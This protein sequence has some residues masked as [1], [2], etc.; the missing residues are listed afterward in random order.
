M[1]NYSYVAIDPRGLETRGRLDVSDQS[2][3]LRRIREM[4]LFPTKVLEANE[5]RGPA[6]ARPPRPGLAKWNLT[7]TIPGF[8]GRV[9]TTSLT[10]F[11]RQLS[12]LV[13]AGL[14]LLR[15]LRLLEEQ[16]SNPTL[17]QI[18]GDLSF[19]IEGGSSLGDAVAAHPRVF[20]R[21]YVN[22]VKAGEISGALEITLRRLAE[23]MEKTQRIK[24][25]IKAA[26][27]YPCAVLSV[28]GAILM[29]LLAYVVPKFKLVFADMLGN[30]RLPVFTRFILAISDTVKAHVFV[31]AGLAGATALLVALSLRTQWGRWSF[32]QLKLKMPILGPV[33]RKASISRFARTL[34]TLVSSGVPILQALTIV[35]ETAGNLVVGRVISSVHNQ[36]K[37]GEAIAPTLK[38]SGVF[39][40]MVAGMVE[41]G[42]QT[43]ALPEM[44]MKV[45]DTYDEDVDNAAS[46]MTSLLEPIMIVLLAVVVGSIVIAMFMPIIQ[47]IESGGLEGQNEKGLAE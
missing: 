25:K 19:A 28:A 43:G 47:V 2:E 45:A 42:E 15:G 12:T 40:A 31:A 4:G 37:E 17:R 8:S 33:F 6:I 30:Q 20:N 18:I 36:V 23:F 38:A 10:V 22:M 21:L 5:R 11:T 14:P 34:G 7:I 44:L 3:A 46:A 29:V 32:D 35:K 41:V 26:M 16:E 9:K 13:E 39:P 27:F 1:S 24:G